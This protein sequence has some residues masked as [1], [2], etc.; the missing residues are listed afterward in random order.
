MTMQVT[1]DS[2][3]VNPVHFE[4]HDANNVVLRQV[5]KRSWE[6]TVDGTTVGIFA[7]AVDDIYAR[8]ISTAVM[9]EQSAEGL[10]EK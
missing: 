10:V 6:L 9:T 2:D 1:A 5:G 4:F 7:P 8:I 3:E